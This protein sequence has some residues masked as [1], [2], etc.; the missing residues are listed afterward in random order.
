MPAQAGSWDF[1]PNTD[2]T[3]LCGWEQHDHTCGVQGALQGGGE[4]GGYTDTSRKQGW[5]DGEGNP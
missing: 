3:G 4:G 2:F 5:K 1:F